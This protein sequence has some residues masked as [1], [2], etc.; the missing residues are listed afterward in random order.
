M[1]SHRAAFYTYEVITLRNMHL[2]DN[3]VVQIIGM[4]SIIL[5]AIL[6]DKINQFCIKHVLH[7]PKLHA[8]LLSISKLVSNG[9]KV[10]FNLN[11]CIVK[12]CDGEVIA[13]APRKQNMYEINFVEVHEVEA[14]NLVQPL[15]GDDVLGL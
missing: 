2:G 15:V 11:K 10:Q 1:T 3:S 4:G 14:T 6:K 7:A 9:L 8:N 13:N 12:F 5:E